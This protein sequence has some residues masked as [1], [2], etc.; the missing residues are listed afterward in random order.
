MRKAIGLLVS[1]A[2]LALIWWQV[3]VDAILAAT[4]QADPRW[5]AAGLLTIVPLTLVTA[6]RLRMLSRTPLSLG[7]ATRLILSASTL[8][9]ILPS[10]MG[11]IAK[12]VA[13]TGRHG[14]G[15]KLAVALVV[16]ERSLDM[17]ALLFWGV[18]ALLWVGLDEPLYLLA[19]LAVAALFALLIVLL[20]PGRLAAQLIALFGRLAPGKAGRWI[21]GFADEWQAGTQWLWAEPARAL[22]VVAV[23]LA[24][25]GGHL[26]QFWLFAQALA[27]VPFLDNMAFATLAI[28]AGLLPFTMA[29]I[30]T[31]DAAILF[32]YR[33]FLSP[34][35][36]AVL[37]VLA[38]LRYLLPAIA[39]LPFMGDYLDRSRKHDPAQNPKSRR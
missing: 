4:A 17:A 27:P 20:S 1:L 8:N 38:T 39:G 10:K 34:G 12:G 14:F 11:D 5:L 37:G 25:W 15:T 22:R 9:L 32:L 18:L 31:R 23:S 3:D 16:M 13:L 29:G 24:I 7:S 19:A 26:L 33:E 21:S 30:G 28:L 2:L 35:Q 6:Q 36:A